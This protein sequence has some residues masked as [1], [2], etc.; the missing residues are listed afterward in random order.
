M[1]SRVLT[2]KASVICKAAIDVLR[3]CTEGSG[4][5]PFASRIEA[6]RQIRLLKSVREVALLTRA[7]HE[8]T[9]EHSRLLI[10]LVSELVAKGRSPSDPNIR[11]LLL[12]IADRFVGFRD[13]PKLF[14]AVLRELSGQAANR[15]PPKRTR[16]RAQATPNMEAV[17]KLLDGRSMVVIGGQRRRSR[18]QALNEAFGLKNLYWIETREHESLRGIKS[19]IGRPDVAVVVLLIKLSSHSFG[20]QI[21]KYC[22]QCGKLLARIRAGYNPRQVA[23]QMMRQ[24]GDRLRRD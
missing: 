12:P 21:Q 9:D 16:S 7:T 19:M 15:R 8:G 10:A 24:C 2:D 17:A 4:T 14:Q 20:P 1:A 3:A 6:R 13:A 23:E 18:E 5:G 22:H 11:E